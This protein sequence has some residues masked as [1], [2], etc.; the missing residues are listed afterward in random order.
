MTRKFRYE[1]KEFEVIRC[2][3]PL[4]WTDNSSHICIHASIYHGPCEM[5]CEGDLKNRPEWCPLVEVKD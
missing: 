1:F 2:A 4:W 5:T 3:C